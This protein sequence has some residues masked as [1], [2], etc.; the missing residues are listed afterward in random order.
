MILGLFLV[1]VFTLNLRTPIISWGWNLNS[2]MFSMGI[3]NKI[4][5]GLI[6]GLILIIF[7]YINLGILSIS[8][9]DLRLVVMMFG[10]II[11]IL[12]LLFSIHLML[13]RQKENSFRNVFPVT[14]MTN[15]IGQLRTAGLFKNYSGKPNEFITQLAIGRSIY[16]QNGWMYS[17]QFWDQ[18]TNLVNE[19]GI[20]RIDHDKVWQEV[21]T[22]FV[23]EGNRVYEDV[24][25]EFAAISEGHFIPTEINETW[26]SKDKVRITFKMD[27]KTHII[28]PKV[29]NDW[30]DINTILQYLN[31]EILKDVDYKFYYGQ[32]DE[33][34]VIGLSEHE[35]NKLTEVSGIEFS[36]TE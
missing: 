6:I 7:R 3:G 13:D 34:L 5:L 25:K 19:F 23:V 22:E 1:M 4:R 2:L 30:A 14:A 18:E 35:K 11:P 32:G 26:E 29:L 17:D 10:Y 28:Y 20:I 12:L 31:N 36:F 24:I 21:D 9:K 15:E 8:N 33:L 16:Q 27:D